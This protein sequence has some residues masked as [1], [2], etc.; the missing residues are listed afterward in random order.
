MVGAGPGDPGLITAK[1]LRCLEQAQVVV[2]DNIADPETCPKAIAS[3]AQRGRLVTAGAHG[4]PL[5]TVDFYQIYHNQ[6]TIMGSPGSRIE[7]LEPCLRQAA[8]GR[9]R[10]RIERIMPL[11]QAAEAHRLV[12]ESPGIG[13]IILDPTLG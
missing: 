11:S 9:L 12:E 6:L 10:A 3:L 13:K 7:D 5:V 4:G 2:Y 1:G 8:S